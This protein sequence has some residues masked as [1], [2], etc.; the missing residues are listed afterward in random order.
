MRQL[1]L[2]AMVGAVWVALLS[3]CGNGSPSGPKDKNAAD[4]VYISVD[5]SFKP[6]IDEQIKVYENAYPSAKIVAQY[7]PEAQCLRDFFRDSATR[8]VVVTRGLTNREEKYFNDSAGYYPHWGSLAADAIVLLVHPSDPDTLFTMQQLRGYL[9]GTAA[10]KKSFVFDGLSATSTVRF[11]TDSILRGAPFDT[12][13]VRAA[14]GSREVIDYVAAN[15]GTV[16]LVGI[17][18]I[19]NPEDIEQVNL[20]KKVRMAYVRCDSCEGQ[21]YV[22]PSQM[23]IMEKR[24]PLVRALHYIHS[25]GINGF[26]AG[27]AAFMRYERGQLIFRR[28]YLAP[29]KMDFN[30][31]N[32]KINETLQK[33]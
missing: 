28:A 3:G 22:K 1:S 13:V 6:I 2:A 10:R 26:A 12:S 24:Y 32:V 19:G 21:P 18:W 33:D 8:M 31:R 20:L 14:K 25:D 23:G 15:P 17:S 11:A 16:G 7:K 27:F 9:S 5:E 30:I 29:L 4:T